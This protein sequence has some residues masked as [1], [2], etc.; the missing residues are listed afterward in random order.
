MHINKIISALATIAVSSALG[1]GFSLYEGSASGVADTAGATAKGGRAGDMYYNPATMVAVTGTVVHAGT[2]LIAPTMEVRAVNPY[3]GATT[4]HKPKSELWPIPHAYIVHQVN[5]DWW[6]GFGMASRTGLGADFDDDWAGR[7]NSTE[8]SILSVNLNPAV[9]YRVCDRL[10]LSLGFDLQI[11][12]ISL[13]QSIDAAGAFGMRRYN[14]PTP[15]PYD[16][17]QRMHGFDVEPG[18]DFGLRLVPVDGLYVGFA[19]HSAIQ[20]DAKG[21]V[22]Y[23]A[24][25]AIRAALPSAFP[26]SHITGD[27]GEPAYWMGSI[28]FDV[29]DRLTLGFGATYSEWSNWN[30]L[31]ITLHDGELLPGKS[32][33]ESE[34][35]WRDVWRFTGGGSYKLNDRW[36]LRASYTYDG[37]PIR[38][39]FEDYLVPADTRDIFAVGASLADG[40]WTWD[41]TYFYENIRDFTSSARVADGMYGGKFT[42]GR[43]HSIAVSVSKQF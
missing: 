15:S 37:S 20:P 7:Y 30:K 24:P 6:V 14:D 43:A 3:T 19:Y 18:W 27:V 34:K 9:T 12:D 33:L 11:F 17:V 22:N 8:A 23:D 2:F 31:C 26:H 35:K 10:A 25:A 38:K 1:A 16:V 32:K 39:G 4:S 41:F 29:T 42:D 28:A 5:E 13:K 21:S 40:P 36:T